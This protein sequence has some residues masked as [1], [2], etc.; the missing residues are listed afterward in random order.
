MLSISSFF[1]E[2]KDVKV[3]GHQEFLV[4]KFKFWK[5]FNPTP[6][7]VIKVDQIC[8][9]DS[10]LCI[11]NKSFSLHHAREIY[12][13]RHL[14]AFEWDALNYATKSFW[15]PRFKEN[16]R[17][18]LISAIT[19]LQKFNCLFFRKNVKNYYKYYI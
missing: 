7:F 9:S 1:I 15:Q 8:H 13:C 10:K 6:C 19:K 2:I 5:F 3:S 16:V 14:S 11:V 17:L 18:L 12:W 4:S